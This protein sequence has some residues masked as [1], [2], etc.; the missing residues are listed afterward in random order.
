[1]LGTT[2]VPPCVP[3][4]LDQR[5]PHHY[6]RFTVNGLQLRRFTSTPVNIMFRDTE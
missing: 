2:P 6:Q 5:Q 4:W 1:M 3:S